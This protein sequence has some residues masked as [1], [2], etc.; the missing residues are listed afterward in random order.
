MG[1]LVSPIE[2]WKDFSVNLD[3]ENINIISEK[4]LGDGYIQR[5]LY[6]TAYQTERGKV[7]AFAQ[8]YYDK[9]N[10]KAPVIFFLGSPVRFYQTLNF[11]KNN[12]KGV[13]VF[14]IDYFG[15]QSD[16]DRY[17]IYPQCLEYANFEKAQ[18]I[19]NTV[20]DSPK[21]TPWYV[22][23]AM[24]RRALTLLEQIPEVDAQKIAILGIKTGANLAWKIGATDNR[25]RCIISM[26]NTGWLGYDFLYKKGSESDQ[27]IPEER[28][29]YLAS[30]STQSYAPLVKTPILVT[31]STN[32]SDATFDRAF[33]TYSRIPENTVSML[34]V[35]PYS[36]KEIFFEYNGTIINWLKN[37]LFGAQLYHPFQP[38]LTVV[39]QDNQLSVQ[40]KVDTSVPIKEM[41]LYQAIETPDPSVRNWTKLN[42]IEKSEGIYE[43]TAQ[44]LDANEYCF[45]FANAVYQD[46]II[47][48]NMHACIPS[49]INIAKANIK[50][51][52]LV[53]DSSM[54]LDCWTAVGAN[55]LFHQCPELFMEKGALD[56][57][58]VRANIGNLATYKIGDPRFKGYE[59]DQLQI[60][61]YSPV[62]QKIT[63]AI[64]NYFNDGRVF[65]YYYTFEAEGADIW[66][67]ITL[68]ASEFKNEDGAMLKSFENAVL[69]YIKSEDK[70][71]VNNIL[72]V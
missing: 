4:D 9:K 68:T 46:F 26:F 27:E 25:A 58:G 47:S 59:E 61:Y 16:S 45:I 7:R 17:T 1:E 24:A 13:N 34:S 52:R 19:L 20:K 72:W 53:Y 70:L 55:E 2:L 69:L 12:L 64:R 36:D 39:N 14:T 38:E 33:D 43:A 18:N 54:G 31:L 41:R 30:L 49:Q 71:L 21:E 57:L 56:M 32:D 23:T 42:C 35:I 63:I 51:S 8:F 15:Y 6:F 50:A 3:D 48:S 62:N 10:K 60:G 11:I 67:K 37:Y 5:Q 44:V 22:W 29:L 65:D 40:I 66:D 28:S